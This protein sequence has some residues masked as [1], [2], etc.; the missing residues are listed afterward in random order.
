MRRAGN[1]E[2]RTLWKRF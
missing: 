2:L 1:V